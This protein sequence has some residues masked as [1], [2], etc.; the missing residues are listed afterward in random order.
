[1]R[2]RPRYID[3]RPQLTI[4]IPSRQ[5][6]PSTLS[7]LSPLS[8][9]QTQISCFSPITPTPS[10]DYAPS[11][12]DD[13]DDDEENDEENDDVEAEAA[14]VT[15][16]QEQPNRPSTIQPSKGPQQKYALPVELTTK[17]QRKY[18][19]HHI[20]QGLSPLSNLHQIRSISC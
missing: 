12:L 9:S 5:S 7:S 10:S 2:P 11:L 15:M 19:W 16:T 8:P 18:C 4:R 6:P 17:A 20:A 14:N 1:M 3:K 13:D